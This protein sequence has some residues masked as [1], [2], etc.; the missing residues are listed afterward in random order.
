MRVKASA[1][2]HGPRSF[3]EA[4]NEGR[5]TG[6]SVVIPTTRKD[7]LYILAEPRHLA[8]ATEAYSRFQQVAE[9]QGVTTPSATFHVVNDIDTEFPSAQ[10]IR[11]ILTDVRNERLRLRNVAS[12]WK[13]TQYFLASL[14]DLAE[15]LLTRLGSLEPGADELNV[16]DI[17][18]GSADN[19]RKRHHP[20]G[21]TDGDHEM[22]DSTP[23]GQH[24]PHAQ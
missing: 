15:A 22:G 14:G 4:L 19:P 3:R 10:E 7:T 20:D 16:Q 17:T 8:S 21:D 12:R 5:F 23:T 1:N 6:P 18:E 2:L 11:T 9:R 24:E 13:P